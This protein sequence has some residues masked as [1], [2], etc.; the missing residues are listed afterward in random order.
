MGTTTTTSGNDTLVGGSG[1][2]ILNGGAGNDTLNGGSGSDTLD[3]GTG[4]HKLSGGSGAD[5]L[6]YK[7]WETQW[8]IGSTVTSSTT[9]FSVSG[10]TVENSTS[11]TSFTGSDV[12]DGG[13]GAAKLSVAD[14][15]VVQIW[16]DPSQLADPAILAEI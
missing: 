15:D 4:I 9:T 2:D 10:G 12:Y 1:D 13:S 11:T 5:T 3:G 14:K 16:L 8:R 7:A 6:I